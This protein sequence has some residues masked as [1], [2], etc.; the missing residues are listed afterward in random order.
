MAKKAEFPNFSLYLY[1]SLD[2]PKERLARTQQNYVLTAPAIE[3][4]SDDSTEY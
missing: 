1:I 2:I 3:D 4:Y